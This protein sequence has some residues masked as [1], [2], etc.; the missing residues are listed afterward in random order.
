[1]ESGRAPCRGSRLN[2]GSGWHVGGLKKG[3]MGGVRM[4]HSCGG[5]GGLQEHMVQNGRGV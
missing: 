1:M 2:D 4:M 5:R 3:G